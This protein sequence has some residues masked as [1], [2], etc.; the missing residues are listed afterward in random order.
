M[1][2]SPGVAIGHGGRH[3]ATTRAEAQDLAR[4]LSGYEGRARERRR[5]PVVPLRDGERLIDLLERVLVREESVEGEAPAVA[6]EEVERAGDDPR[7]VLDHAHDLLRPPDEHGRLEFDL[8][9]AAD[10][11]D[12]EVRAARPKHFDPLRDHLRKADEVTG[13]VRAAT[14][15]P[16]PYERDALLAV[17]DLLEVDRV[18][19]AE[20]PRQLESPRELIDHDHRRRAHVPGDRRRL[21]PEA[22]G[23]LDHDAPA[24]GQARLPEPEDHLREGAVHRCDHLVGQRVGDE[25]ERAARPQIVVLGERAVEVRKLGRPSRPLDLR[26]TRRGLVG[27]AG[28]AAPAGVEVGVGDAVAF[29]E[30]APQRVRLDARAEPGHPAGHLVAE[31]PAVVGQAQWRVAPPEVEVG[32]AHVGERD[33]DEDGVGLHLGQWQLPELERLAGTEEDRGL[34]PAHRLAPLPTSKASWRARTASSAYLSSMTHEIAISEVEIIWMLIPSLESVANIFAATPPWLRMP[35]PTIETLAT[36]SSWTTP[37]APIDRATSSS[38]TTARAW[39]PRGRVN[40]MSVYP[41]RLMFWTIMSTTMFFAAIA[42]NAWAAMPGRSGT[43]RMEIFAWLRSCVT[44]VTTTSSMPCSSFVTSVP[45]SGLNVE[46]T[47][48]V[49]PYF[50]ANSTERDCSTFAPRLAISSISSYETRASFLAS[51]TMAGSAV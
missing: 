21:D 43:L 23:A 49:T 8:G 22:A 39:S 33:A 36:R 42:P 34:A 14:A 20:R 13:D 50:F 44:P 16:L 11:P 29:P 27:E 46:R 24:E 1:G 30:R 31:D 51:G 32:T 4:G 3:R 12:L 10:R 2:P 48:T 37:R 25:E 19:G 45:G 38:A 18:V 15:R 17:G 6:H 28:V 9:A 47:W 35:T 40:D 41:S 5:L 26:R 7:I